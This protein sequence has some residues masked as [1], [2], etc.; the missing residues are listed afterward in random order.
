MVDDPGR[1]VPEIVERLV[2]G[3]GRVTEVTQ[4]SRSLTDVIVALAERT[5]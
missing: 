2:R 1:H 3:G 4:E 5:N